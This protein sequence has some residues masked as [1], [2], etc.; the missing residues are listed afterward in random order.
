MKAYLNSISG[1]DD[2]IISMYFSKRHMDYQIESDIRDLCSRCLTR[3]GFMDTKETNE[4]DKEKFDEYMTKLCKFGIRHITLLRF[5]DMSFTV[6]GLHRAGQDD[7]DAHACRYNNRIIRESSRLADFKDGEKSDYYKD[8]ILTTEEV[9]RELSIQTPE[10]IIK[11]GVKYIKAVNG[12]IR[13]DLVDK[14]DVKRGLYMLS[15]PSSFIFRVNLT[16]WAH[17]YKERNASGGANPEVKELAESIADL[18]ENAIPYF[19][20]DLFMKI[21][22]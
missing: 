16:E 14:N 18:I 6:Y 7:W 20:R 15:I 3:K 12:Y 11:D 2:A 4:E 13:E 8:K 22:N 9:M 5:V 1:I 19:N 21:N 17:V 10:F